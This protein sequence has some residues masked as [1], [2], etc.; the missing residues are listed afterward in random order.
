V[1]C[2]PHRGQY[3]HQPFVLEPTGSCPGKR[4]VGAADAAPR[5]MA[6]PT[7]VAVPIADTEQL[8]RLISFASEVSRPADERP[9]LELRDLI[10]S[11]HRDLLALQPEFDPA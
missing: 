10:D 7:M 11:L 5:L 8:R 2:S 3:A 1:Y 4:T 6:M 9:D